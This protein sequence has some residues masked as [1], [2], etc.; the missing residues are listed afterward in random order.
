M[1]YSS[2]TESADHTTNRPKLT[3]KAVFKKK[4]DKVAADKE[5]LKVSH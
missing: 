5:V 2:D 1:L 3:F 4:S